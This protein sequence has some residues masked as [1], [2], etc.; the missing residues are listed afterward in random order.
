MPLDAALWKR[1]LDVQAGTDE[2]RDVR[3]RLRS[4][5]LAFRDHAAAIAGEINRDLPYFTA[6]DITH[7]DAL[8]EIASIIAG[9]AYLLNPI[10]AFVLGGA[11][12]IHD[13][14]NG[15]AAYPGG[16]SDLK[17]E[18]GWADAVA[19][20]F[21][22]KVGR[23]PT[24]AEIEN[25]PREVEAAAVEELLRQTHAKQAERLP[26]TGWRHPQEH[27]TWQL[28]DDSEVRN[29][30]GELVGRIA[31]SHWWDV[32]RL[33]REFG[34]KIGAPE[35]C[36][37]HWTIDPLKVACLMRLADA[38]H[39]DAR[40]APAFLRVLRRVSGYS[41]LHWKFQERLSKP[42]VQHERL[43]Y[44]SSRAFGVDDA[45][46]WWLCFDVVR[47]VDSELQRVDALLAETQRQQFAVRGVAGAEAP[48][49]LTRHIR[50]NGWIP[51]DAQVRVTDVPLLVESL[52]GKNLYGNNP[53][54][55]LRE[56]VQNAAD[57]V[58]AR[59]LLEN[60]PANWGDITVR[61]GE[62]EHGNWIEVED[63]G[64]GM[65]GRV[66][67]GPLLDFGKSYWGSS[68]MREESPGL[69]AKGFEP[70]GAYGIGFFSVFIWG[71][72]VRVTSRRA[73]DA[74]EQTK[75]LEF[76]GGLR[77]RPVLR[78]APVAQRILDGG[79]RIRIWL[80]HPPLSHD[81]IFSSKATKR[82]NLGQLCAWIAPTLDV[83]LD[84]ETPKGRIRAVT[85]GDWLTMD[86][87]SFL[88]RL[89]LR[90]EE[91]HDRV[92]AELAARLTVISDPSGRPVGRAAFAT[93]PA[94]R[95]KR[96]VGE[97]VGIVTV[98]GL[99][100]CPVH[101]FAGALIGE[102]TR[103]ARDLAIPVVAMRDLAQ[104]AT[105]QATVMPLPSHDP[106]EDRDADARLIFACR[107]DTSG[108]PIARAEVGWLTAGDVDCWARDQQEV[109]LVQDAAISNRERDSKD[110]VV[111]ADNVLA[112][113]VSG[114]MFISVNTTVVV[115]PPAKPE[116]GEEWAFYSA[117]LVGAVAEALA[118]AWSCPVESVLAISERGDDGAEVTRA[119]GTCNG[120]EVVYDVMALRRPPKP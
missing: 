16:V 117:S 67:S 53:L 33:E 32:D 49:H 72:R 119:I 88:Q 25:P 48:S 109:V 60:R 18:D 96:E 45:Q 59:R 4:S 57:A 63:N 111:L 103:A 107:G 40:R 97:D 50:V 94:Y 28:I 110:R 69:L 115:W 12:L 36:P 21:K 47:M 20:S 44:S 83:N 70:T 66:L 58:R 1:T 120:A 7:L 54:V 89:L 51:V 42:M 43:V 118:R 64:I 85:A 23:T 99:R 2:F 74:R 65:S 91:K 80:K 34:E 26:L 3:D 39:I 78:E 31:H 102:P 55:P 61:L 14:G 113:D 37:P 81:G 68:L 19:Y 104:W 73:E 30:L 114:A 52:G 29:R 24:P 13:L 93:R 77:T 87:A 10:E 92:V 8:W 38:A 90:S 22:Y 84:V 82:A 108:F 6:H 112:V 35:F 105:H 101:G 46:A 11:F 79:T 116:Y 71:S 62:D 56:L 9:D 75:V 15:L 76:D 98:G 106:A 27:T 5:F 100:S 95:R 17:H 41:D 86:G